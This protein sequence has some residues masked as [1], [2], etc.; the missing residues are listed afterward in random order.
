VHCPLA[1]K[2]GERARTIEHARAEERQR[3][4]ERVGEEK[5]KGREKGSGTALGGE[6]DRESERKSERE[7][8]GERGRKRETISGLIFVLVHKRKEVARCKTS[9]LHFTCTTLHVHYKCAPNARDASESET[10]CSYQLE[11]RV[12]NY[13]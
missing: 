7:R 12:T 11:P 13:V 3:G 8:K 6:R 10:S 1:L 4:R 9:D 5:E 2:L